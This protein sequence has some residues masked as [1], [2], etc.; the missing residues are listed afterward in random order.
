[1]SYL[2]HLET[3]FSHCSPPYRYATR[4]P[5]GGREPVK[6]GTLHEYPNIECRFFCMA[7]ID[8]YHEASTKLSRPSG[9]DDIERRLIIQVLLKSLF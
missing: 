2:D 3:T 9:F 5:L 4:S 6:T 7:P 1:M 8:I